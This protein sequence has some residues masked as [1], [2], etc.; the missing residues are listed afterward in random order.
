MT[1]TGN[2]A[3][4][5]EQR[6]FHGINGALKETFVSQF[7]NSDGIILGFANS[8]RHVWDAHD[9]DFMIAAIKTNRP[10]S[11]DKTR[12]Y[13]HHSTR[14]RSHNIGPRIRQLSSINFFCFF[15]RSNEI[16][17]PK[18]LKQIV[19]INTSEYDRGQTMPF[20]TISHIRTV[21][22]ATASH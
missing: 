8:F 12:S 6:K 16:L 21:Q 18:E 4:K 11:T 15:P 2:L 22:I 17:S 5:C 3:F 9:M 19:P 10:D 20:E 13:F 1:R 14:R 7:H